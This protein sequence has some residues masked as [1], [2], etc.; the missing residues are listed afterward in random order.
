MSNVD[1]QHAQLFITTQH[2]NWTGARSENS[3]GL[4]IDCRAVNNGSSPFLQPRWEPCRNYEVWERNK[5]NSRPSGSLEDAKF[6]LVCVLWHTASLC[7]F[8]SHRRC[9]FSPACNFIA[10]SFL[11]GFAASVLFGRLVDIAL[12]ATWEVLDKDH[13]HTRTNLYSK[14]LPRTKVASQRM[15]Y[16]NKSHFRNFTIIKKQGTGKCKIFAIIFNK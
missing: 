15:L 2:Y 5:L 7:K 3:S 12:L 10:L 13:S 16:F 6:H 1:Y 14:S 9:S 4:K 8:Y 11:C